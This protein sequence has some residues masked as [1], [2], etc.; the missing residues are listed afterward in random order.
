[1]VAQKNAVA[2]DVAS[3]VSEKN[4]MG[5]W[6]LA[7]FGS[8]FEAVSAAI[9][10][11]TSLGQFDFRPIGPIGQHINLSGEA[12]KDP[13]LALLLEAELGKAF[14][15]SFLV[16]SHKDSKVLG[17]I[18]KLHFT[19]SKPPNRSVLKFQKNRNNIMSGQVQ[20][21][22]E[23]PGVLDFLTFND[24]N[25]FNYVVEMKSVESTLVL[26]DDQA[27]D[28]FS[29][30]QKVPRNAR[31]A[32]TKQFYTY[33]P[34]TRTSNYSS[35]YMNRPNG[36]NLLAK[37]V[38]A[39]AKRIDKEIAE[40]NAN[41]TTIGRQIVA[42]QTE[43]RGHENELKRIQ[44]EIQALNET[45][46]TLK[47]NLT[48]EKSVTIELQ[49]Q[50]SLEE[51]SRRLDENR[52]VAKEL[53]AAREKAKREKER[54]GMEESMAL[55]EMKSVKE[56]YDKVLDVTKD[57]T[58]LDSLRDQVTQER[59]CVSRL[60]REIKAAQKDVEKLKE[61]VSYA[62]TKVKE[63]KEL[64]AKA[65]KSGDL[66]SDTEHLTMREIK[67]REQEN[68]REQEAI[69]AE[70][71]KK[72]LD[73]AEARKKLMEIA[74]SLQGREERLK[75]EEDTLRLLDQSAKRRHILYNGLRK[76]ISRNLSLKFNGSMLNHRLEGELECNHKKHELVIKAK[77]MTVNG[78]SAN[79]DTY[80]P[81]T[82]L[83]G[84]E[85]ARVLICLL[86]ACWVSLANPFRIMDE[87]DVFMDDRARNEVEK[88]LHD[89]AST[90]QHQYIFISPQRSTIEGAKMIRLGEDRTT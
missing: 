69:L 60:V 26:T 8:E 77:K 3:L 68:K 48:K 85:R 28:L 53:E 2:K 20:T 25:V 58:T 23:I 74:A 61:D 59:A 52:V 82:N 40:G 49:E 54:Y 66:G 89:F 11:A 57:T 39:E 65:L 83:S 38:G 76:A 56:A 71:K 45:V 6:S 79:D 44:S 29:D 4:R 75:T 46:R 50:N 15:R 84:G 51:L 13:E 21:S 24:S 9:M 41:M 17:E 78:S 36:A 18:F 35:F 47:Q 16:N 7:R 27:R 32:I 88:M 70:L 63:H 64:L 43:I 67:A 33:N 72:G 22:R 19:R 5:T 81:L 86:E 30:P 31:K 55:K 10:K 42:A 14:L 90:D 80:L 12:S 73:R 37:D 87:W 62:E 34:S 1:M